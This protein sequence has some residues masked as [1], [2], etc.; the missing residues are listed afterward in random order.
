[1][2]GLLARPWWT[3]ITAFIKFTF[4]DFAYVARDRISR[5]FMCHVFRCELPARHIASTLCGICKN[6]IAKWNAVKALGNDASGHVGRPTD[7]PSLEKHLNNGVWNQTTGCDDILRSMCCF[8]A[9][10]LKYWM[11]K[12]NFGIL[13]R[14]GIIQSVLNELDLCYTGCNLS[15]QAFFNRQD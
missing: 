12:R 14:S 15:V 2:L 8:I 6:V 5:K 10:F 7:L 3:K 4:R 1:M 13:V 11:I 9:V